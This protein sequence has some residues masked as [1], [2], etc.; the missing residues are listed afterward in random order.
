MRE[1]GIGKEGKRDATWGTVGQTLVRD[2]EER[3]DGGCVE[4][5]MHTDDNMVFRL[6]LVL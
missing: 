4:K 5:R 1:K 2:R 6:G 3:D